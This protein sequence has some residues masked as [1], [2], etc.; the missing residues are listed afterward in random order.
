MEL[1]PAEASVPARTSDAGATEP[2]V[3]PAAFAS[4]LPP[5]L[6][7]RRLISKNPPTILALWVLE[8]MVVVVEGGG[9]ARGVEGGRVAEQSGGF[10]RCYWQAH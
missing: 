6:V 5:Q 2:G 10:M 8:A 9:L 3:S 1:L 7:S 4:F